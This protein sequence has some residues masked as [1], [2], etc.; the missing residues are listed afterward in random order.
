MT[1]LDQQTVQGYAAQAGFHGISQQTIVAIA[2]CE[3]GFDTTKVNPTDP[4]GGS[5]GILQINGSHFHPGGTTQACAFNPQCAFQYAYTLSKQG[6]NFTD[7]TTYTNG[8]AAAKMQAGL[9]T[10]TQSATKLTFPEWTLPFMKVSVAEAEATFNHFP[11]SAEGWKEGGVDWTPTKPGTPITALGPGQVVGAGYFCR[12]PNNF[13]ASDYRTC[14]GQAQ[15]YGVVTIRTMNKDGTQT[16]IYYQHIILDPSIKMSCSGKPTGQFINQGQIIGYSNPSF[17]IEVGVN[18]PWGGIWGDNHPGPHIDPIPYLHDLILT[19]AGSFDPNS[20]GF[21][22]TNTSTVPFNA[23][24]TVQSLIV[25]LKPD[26]GVIS[27]LVALDKLMFLQNPFIVNDPAIEDTVNLQFAQFSFTDPIK[28]AQDVALNIVGDIGA[29][30][31]RGGFILAGLYICF[32]VFG[33]VVNLSGA[34]ETTGNL[35]RTGALLSA[36]A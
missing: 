26:A 28:Y 5:F 20:L 23:K 14:G 22:T 30:I 35:L 6:T 1:V 17:N 4:F 34:L 25:H 18:V 32:K 31:I 3:S 15:G 33:T 19:G 36:A 21:G 24:Q 11:T 13:C 27:V 12:N 2:L 8:C 10:S 7:W 9:V 16:D 29:L